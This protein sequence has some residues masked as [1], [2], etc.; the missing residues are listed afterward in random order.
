MHVLIYH[1]ASLVSYGFS[2]TLLHWYISFA[3]LVI[4]VL[5]QNKFEKLMHLV[6]FTLLI[7]HD[8]RSSESQISRTMARKF[9]TWHAIPI[10]LSLCKFLCFR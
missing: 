1:I 9:T 4:R 7:Y 8:A 2:S 3:S 5:F 10:P 6:G